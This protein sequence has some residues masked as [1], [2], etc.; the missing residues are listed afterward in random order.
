M[1]DASTWL[2]EAR[3]VSLADA[4]EKFVHLLVILARSCEVCRVTFFRDNEVIAVN[5]G[6]DFDSIETSGHELNESHLRGRILTRDP[7]WSQLE[8]RFSTP[9]ICLLYIVQVA[10]EH[11]FRIRQRSIQPRYRPQLARAV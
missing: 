7:G 11:L 2:P 10:I 8:I 6:R 1:D 5:S 3:A 4:L 9:N